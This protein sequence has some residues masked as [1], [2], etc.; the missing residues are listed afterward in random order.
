M[1]IVGEFE[2]S[3]KPIDE[4]RILVVDVNYCEMFYYVFF[5]QT[6]ENVSCVK[7]VLNILYT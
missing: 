1:I 4:E 6:K 5:F 7:H 3:E 2:R